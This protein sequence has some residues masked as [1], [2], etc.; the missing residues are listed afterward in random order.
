MYYVNHLEA[1]DFC[2][3]ADGAG[4]EGG[5]VAARVGISLADRVQWEYA[6]RAGTKT[7]TAFGDTLSSQAG[8]LRRQLPVQRGGKRTDPD[9]AAAE[10]FHRYGV[11]KGSYFSGYTQPVGSY[12]PNAWGLYDMHG[13][14]AE[15]CR[16][17]D[18]RVAR[19]DGSRG[20]S[21][22]TLTG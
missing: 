9:S 1:S 7:A 15:W 6:C 16:D 11:Y 2:R 20:R 3:E 12:P 17:W 14:V 22:G 13:N 8:E 4:T 19:R 18:R 21:L 5:A 10:G